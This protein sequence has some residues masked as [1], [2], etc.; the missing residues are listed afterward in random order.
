VQKFL[1][2]VEQTE[3]SENLQSDFD[4]LLKRVNEFPPANAPLPACLGRNSDAIYMSLKQLLDSM[5]L[6][7]T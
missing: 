6:K 5:I 2:K 4:A 1:T 7:T 3:F